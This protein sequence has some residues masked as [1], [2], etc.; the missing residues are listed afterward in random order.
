MELEVDVLG[1]LE[2]GLEPTAGE[3]SPLGAFDVDFDEVGWARE[4]KE[5]KRGNRE[6]NPF[7]ERAMD[8]VGG[9]AHGVVPGASERDVSSLF[10]A[11]S[12]LKYRD[13]ALELI[14][15][16]VGSETRDLKRLDSEDTNSFMS[17]SNRDRTSMSTD[18]NSSRKLFD[19]QWRKPGKSVLKNFRIN[20]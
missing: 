11:N 19:R 9:A 7:I 17:K 10:G 6:S 16:H 3:D 5:L 20:V 4:V 15:F 13:T 18:V 8:E 1:V 2:E 12:R 14:P